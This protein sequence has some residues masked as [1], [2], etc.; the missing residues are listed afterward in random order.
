[1]SREFSISKR[2]LLSALLIFIAVPATIIGGVVFLDDRKYYFI[3]LM[4]IIYAMIPF[5]L[6]FE[7][8]RPQA[9]EIILLA[10]MTAIAVAGRAAFF[11]LP[12]FKPVVA[13]IIITGV[14]FGKEAGFLVGALTALISNFY[15][16]MG[17]FTPWQMFSLG[18]IG[19]LAGLLVE[20]GIVKKNRLHLSIFGALST[21][22]IFGLIMDFSSILMWTSS[23]TWELIVATY[24][25]GSMFNVMHALATVFFI[26]I[27]SRPMIEKLERVK[28]KYGVLE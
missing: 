18:I 3:S 21:L 12:Q 5:F 13:I 27:F 20:K 25:A 4:V 14:S 11:M 28:A 23:I 9:R 2:M 16:G 7:G 17:P 22:F 15:F 6:R 19:F 24:V 8:R 10:V 1:M 26:F